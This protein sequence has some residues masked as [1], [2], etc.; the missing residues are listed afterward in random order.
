MYQLL[1]SWS[2]ISL[3]CL[4]PRIHLIA[5]IGLFELPPSSSMISSK[6]RSSSAHSDDIHGMFPFPCSILTLSIQSG[7]KWGLL[8]FPIDVA[9][10]LLVLVII[11]ACLR[12]R[13]RPHHPLYSL[14]EEVLHSFGFMSQL[15]Y[16][17]W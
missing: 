15:P 10:L 12:S 13:A 4:S 8:L 11:I 17:F 1:C 7:G 9:A 14:A 6:R 3:E 2:M 16:S 5:F